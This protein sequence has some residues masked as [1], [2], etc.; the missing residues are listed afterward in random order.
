VKRIKVIATISV[1]DDGVHCGPCVHCRYMR[2]V[3]CGL[4]EDEQVYDGKRV[5]KCL[6]SEG[7][8]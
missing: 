7:K 2:G 4:F 3:K 6:G 1:D 8:E 5:E